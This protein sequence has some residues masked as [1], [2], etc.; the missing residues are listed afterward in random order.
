ML[1]ARA[2]VPQQR[3]A[4]DET[5]VC[6]W[7]RIVWSD[8]SRLYQVVHCLGVVGLRVSHRPD[9]CEQDSKLS[10]GLGLLGSGKQ[11][12]RVAAPCANGVLFYSLPCVCPE[13]VLVT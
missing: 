2:V 8:I 6:A 13:P 4:V 10:V 9:R 7:V 12:V 11:R 1:G 3:L 5:E